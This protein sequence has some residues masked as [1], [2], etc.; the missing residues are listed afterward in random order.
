MYTDKSLSVTIL[1]PVDPFLF[2]YHWWTH[3]ARVFFQLICFWLCKLAIIIKKNS[4]L[5]YWGGWNLYV[6]SLSSQLKC[7]QSFSRISRK[8]KCI[9]CHEIWW[10]CI[11][12]YSSQINLHEIIQYIFNWQSIFAAENSSLQSWKRNHL[13]QSDWLLFPTL[14]IHWI[15]LSWHLG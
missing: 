15:Y 9:T 7:N 11:S 8:K 13:W 5:Q 12:K 3:I 14:L 1:P 4:V 10:S 2:F 6:S